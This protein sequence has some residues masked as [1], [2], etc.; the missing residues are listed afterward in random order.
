VDSIAVH[1]LA[2]VVELLAEVGV[3][4]ADHVVLQ[5]DALALCRGRILPGEVA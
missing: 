1:R 3:H 2:G 4:A 5:R